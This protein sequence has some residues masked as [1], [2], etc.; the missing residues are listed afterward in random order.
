MTGGDGRLGR[1]QSG[2]SFVPQLVRPGHGPARPADFRFPL[3][4][5]ELQSLL[6]RSRSLEAK[7]RRR[8]V[9]CRRHTAVRYSEY[10]VRRAAGPMET[11]ASHHAVSGRAAAGVA[12]SDSPAGRRWTRRNAAAEC[13]QCA[14]A[15]PD[16]RHRL[17]RAGHGVATR[18]WAGACS[19]A[20][21]RRPARAA[22]SRFTRDYRLAA[23]RREDLIVRDALR[24]RAAVTLD[25]AVA[26][27]VRPLAEAPP[28]QRRRLQRLRGR[29]QRAGHGGLGPGPVRHPVRRLAAPRRRAVDHRAGAGE[30]A[31][32]VAEDLRR[33]AVA[34]A[35]DR[36]RR[37]RDFRRAVRRSPR[38]P[39][40]RR[41]PCCRWTCSFP[42]VRRTR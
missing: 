8:R 10:H 26:A 19:A 21:A 36:R 35:G 41:P 18:H 34:E 37:V 17:D 42:A 3:V 24:G 5:Q 32:G 38:S 39:Q 33:R 13:R 11:R 16:R 23:S 22:R 2:R 12:A 29:H 6:L 14:A 15:L 1:L 40:R 9:R 31:A 4:Q 27:A 7:D 25:E 20:S 30:H 28:G